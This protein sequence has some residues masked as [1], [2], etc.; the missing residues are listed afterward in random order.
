MGKSARAWAYSNCHAICWRVI[1][2]RSSFAGYILGSSRVSG[3]LTEE[4]ITI[5]SDVRQK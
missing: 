2:R 1:D 3:K 4:M 5:S